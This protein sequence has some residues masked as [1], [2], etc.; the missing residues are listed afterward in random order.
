M[1]FQMH[2]WGMLYQESLDRV[3]AKFAVREL[4]LA[5]RTPNIEGSYLLVAVGSF[6]L[7]VLGL[8]RGELRVPWRQAAMSYVNDH[9]G[10]EAALSHKWR[11]GMPRQR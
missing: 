7:C 3:A 10:E 11:S 9:H 8:L 1:L 6:I 5:D 4:P 2:L